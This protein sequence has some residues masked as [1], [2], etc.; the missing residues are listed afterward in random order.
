[1]KSFISFITFTM[2]LAII[3]GVGS[4]L[5][6]LQEYRKPGPLT[7]TKFVIV[8]KGSGMNA[9][10]AQLKEEG[11]IANPFVFKVSAR[12]PPP[13]SPDRARGLRPVNMKFH[14]RPLWHR[15]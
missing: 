6:G 2:T 10:A 15:Y 8:G 9:I 4:A 11:A 13:T 1:M 7:E 5:W 12:L 3:A 14:R